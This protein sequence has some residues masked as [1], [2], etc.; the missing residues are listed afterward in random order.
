MSLG[1][2]FGSVFA[3]M[4]RDPRVADPCVEH[5]AAKAARIAIAIAP[6]DIDIRGVG[7]NSL[8]D[9]LFTLGDHGT[10]KPLEDRAV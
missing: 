4:C 8:C 7:C 1:R 9:D 5:R 10:M 3:P 6:D 2:A